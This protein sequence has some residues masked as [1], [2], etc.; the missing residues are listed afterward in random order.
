MCDGRGP[1]AMSATASV[2]R[3][4]SGRCT[5]SAWPR[6]ATRRG[7]CASNCSTT[8]TRSRLAR[9]SV[10][11]GWPRPRRP[12]R[13]AIRARLYLD[14]HQEGWSGTHSRQWHTTLRDY[15]FPVLGEL[16]VADID[17]AAVLK[18]I[19]PIWKV[20]TVTAARVRARIESVLDYAT[21]SGFRAGDNPA[22]ALRAA[23]PKQSRAH[24]VEHHAALPWQEIPAFMA[25]LRQEPTALA[26]ALEFLIL[27]AARTSEMTGAT[28]GEL[29]LATRTWA[30][31]AS[32]MKARKEHRVPLSDYALKI[33]A[34]T[35]RKGPR[36]YGPFPHT[37]L[38]RLVHR[39]R[40]DVTVHGFRS[41]FRDWARETTAFPDGVVEAALAH[42]VGS[43][44][45][46]AYARGDLFDKRRKLMAAWADYCSRPEVRAQS[47]TLIRGTR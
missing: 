27:T 33:L 39:L 10:A 23:L 45:V 14:L 13:F 36:V 12:C 30:I 3:W 25:T 1:F 34:D 37:A 22:R 46:Q 2:A 5:P 42:A 11:L 15:V 24:R 7:D 43:K 17:Q 9:P 18:V 35:P 32:R 19:E 38:S 21:A 41:A 31:P 47:V 40:P 4:G 6:L 44:V 28:W 8:W 26:R 16:A 20:K 29:D